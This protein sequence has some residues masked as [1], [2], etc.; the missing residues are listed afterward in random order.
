[1][2]KRERERERVVEKPDL[3]ERGME[4]GGGGAGGGEAE[5]DGQEGR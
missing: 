3:R 4:G 1:M 2:R 5:R